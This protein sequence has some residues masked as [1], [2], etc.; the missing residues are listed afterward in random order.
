MAFSPETYDNIYKDSAKYG[1]HYTESTYYPV[2]EEAVKHIEGRV[3]ELGCGTG[4]FAQMIRDTI[5]EPK[6][7]GVDY[8]KEA[9]RQAKERNPDMNFLCSDVFKTIIH[10]ADTFVM[11]ELLEHI[12]DDTLLIGKLPKGKKAVFSVP[13]FEAENHYRCFKNKKEFK[14]IRNKFGDANTIFLCV[15]RK[16]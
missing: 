9:I 7:L 11:L 1:C 4:Q 16:R 5:L 6:Y 12:K 2:W 8:S 10:I 15:G 13:N 14:L 3:L